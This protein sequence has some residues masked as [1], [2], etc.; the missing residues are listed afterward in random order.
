MKAKV[1]QFTEQLQPQQSGKVNVLRLKQKENQS[2]P[3][4]EN[5]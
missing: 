5:F 1:G 4:V 2:L 3:A